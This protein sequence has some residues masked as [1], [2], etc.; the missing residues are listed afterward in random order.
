MA[1]LSFLLGL[2]LGIGIW[3]WR[4]NRLQ[5]QL[6]KMLGVLHTNSSSTSLSVTSRLRQ[7]I[8]ASNQ[9]REKLEEQLQTQQRLLEVA[10]FGYL[11]VDEENRLLWCN[12]QARQLLDINRWE[13]GQLRLLLELVRSYELDRLIE[14]TRQQKQPEMR[15]WVFHPSCVDSA[16]IGKVRSLTL[17][18]FSWP[19]PNEEVGVFLENRQ[20]LIEL[21]QSRNQWFSDLAHEIRT[22][23]TSIRLVAE[24]LQGR[25]EGPASRWVQQ[26]LKETN[27]LINLVQAWLELC[28]L[29][30]NP[31]QSLTF[32][33]IELQS[34]IHSAW[35]SLEPLAQLNQITL[36]YS[37]PD[38]L[39]IRADAARLTQVF[40]NL[41]DNAI[42]YSPPQTAIQVKVT[43]IEAAEENSLIQIDIIDSGAGFSESDLPHVFER[44][45]RGDPSR[46]RL[47][48]N[49]ETLEASS[50]S[51]GS[52][53]GLSIVQQIVEAHRGSV[54]ARNHP[55]TGGA[56]LQL[57]L[58]D[59]KTSR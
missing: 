46:Q 26:L 58:S 6:K 45:Y 7:E 38:T 17:R 24:T 15:E 21:A 43:Q 59:R 12:Q 3:L 37:G 11:L 30:K 20:P 32:Q 48:T 56:W 2:A 55:G 53:L 52:G 50:K 28:N 42:K 4:E 13:P 33:T 18:A 25:L 22:P 39:Y 51:S 35:Q 40:L 41:F 27:R 47:P 9:L 36:D 19:L 54:T 34:L 29:E 14:Q 5:Q 57:N 1:L 10:P 16:S 49:S 44:L 31:S 8:A 23:L